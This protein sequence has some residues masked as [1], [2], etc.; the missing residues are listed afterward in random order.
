MSTSSTASPPWPYSDETAAPVPG[1]LSPALI[2]RIEGL[3]E[4]ERFEVAIGLLDTLEARQAALADETW[5]LIEYL[6]RRY[7]YSYKRLGPWLGW[8]VQGAH[9]RLRGLRERFGVDYRPQ[10]GGQPAQ[11]R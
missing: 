11:G 6:Q 3:N 8:S 7:G 10:P 5:G 2:E 1:L 4:D 9:N